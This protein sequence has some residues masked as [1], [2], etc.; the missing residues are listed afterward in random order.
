MTKFFR[1]LFKDILFKLVVYSCSCSHKQFRTNDFTCIFWNIFFKQFKM[2]TISYLMTICLFVCFSIFYFREQRY[3]SNM[4]MTIYVTWN[5]TKI[6]LQEA[7]KRRKLEEASTASYP[8][9]HVISRL[10]IRFILS[11]IQQIS[12]NMEIVLKIF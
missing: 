10:L 4:K 3:S 1:D 12:N 2:D 7:R 9:P 6:T 5:K 8:K 11:R